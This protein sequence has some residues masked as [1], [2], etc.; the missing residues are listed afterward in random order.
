[1]LRASQIDGCG[2]CADVHTKD[3]A[4]AGE[5]PVRVD[6]V[7]TWRET[8]VF[9]DADRAAL[10]PTEQGTRIADASGGVTD[11][12][13][14]NAAERRD[15]ERLGALVSLIALVNASD[16]LG[17]ISRQRGGDHQPGRFD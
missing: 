16:R 1:M 6:L 7:A 9:T 5:T 2:F 8:T 12:A 11:E 17:V 14:A 3:L 13:W 4:L 15:E 10:E